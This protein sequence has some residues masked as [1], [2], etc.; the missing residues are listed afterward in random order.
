MNIVSLNASNVLER[1]N[2]EHDNKTLATKLKISEEVKCEIKGIES[3]EE[4]LMAAKSDIK[5]V[6]MAEKLLKDTKKS[7]L[8]QSSMALLSQANKNSND[9]ISLLQ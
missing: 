1:K 8:E 4:N 5:N 2:I 3:S 7:I 6:D 9:V